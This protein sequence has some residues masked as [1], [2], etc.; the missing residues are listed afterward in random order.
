MRDSDLYMAGDSQDYVFDGSV[1]EDF[2]ISEEDADF[3]GILL[4]EG[5]DNLAKDLM[6]LLDL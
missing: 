2:D 6:S 3:I 5:D 4:E 1:W